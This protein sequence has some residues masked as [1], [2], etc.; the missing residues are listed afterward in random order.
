MTPTGSSDGAITP[1]VLP[2]SQNHIVGKQETPIVEQRSQSGT[3]KYRY[4]GIRSDQIRLLLVH[5]GAF[6]DPI[7]CS[8]KP[9]NMEDI[10]RLNIN[11]YALSYAWGKR[12]SSF[13]QM[14]DIYIRD[15]KADD[16]PNQDEPDA[17]KQAATLSSGTM[18]LWPNLFDAL[19]GLRS[20]G[21]DLWFWI[22]AIS[23][24]QNNTDEKT[25]QLPK[26]FDIYSNA[27][28]VCVW[29]GKEMTDIDFMMEDDTSRKATVNRRAQA[30]NQCRPYATV[31]RTPRRV[32]AMSADN[33]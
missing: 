27:I 26:M 22:D 13:F 9:V 21:E 2:F 18:K 33:T 7:N 23:I 17:R 16:S 4:S 29:L 10:G 28:S 20:V 15:I 24:N 12:Q 19:K 14:L 32:W 1:P 25:N 31:C 3:D 30:C 8:M 5:K 11:Y 6:D